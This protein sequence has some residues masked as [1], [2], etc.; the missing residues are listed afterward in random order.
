MNQYNTLNLKLFSSQFKLKSKIKNR[1]EATLN[2]WSN[3]I[4]NSNDEINFSH[5]LL[6]TDKQV[7]KICK[8]FANKCFIN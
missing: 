1:T 4:E 5:K 6:L 3:F 2:L 8:T 7:S